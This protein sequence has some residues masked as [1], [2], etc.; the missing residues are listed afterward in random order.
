MNIILIG[1]MGSGKS[2]IGQNLSQTLNLD[3]LD[4]D[5]YI[6]EAE[7]ASISDLFSTKGEIYFRKIE[8]RYLKEI[9]RNENVVISLGG[10]TPC[11]GNNMQIINEA[12]NIKSLYLKA[13]IP[14]LVDRLFNERAM[15][16]MIA[17][18][19]TKDEMTEFIGKHLFERSY[20]YNQ[21]DATLTIDKKSVEEISAAIVMELF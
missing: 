2:T 11:Y 4:L 14:T 20:F 19:N 16:P 10:G 9:I 6:E 18:L 1:Y 13:S 3:F 5:N 21:A 12:T 8:N 15:R 7:G 17:H